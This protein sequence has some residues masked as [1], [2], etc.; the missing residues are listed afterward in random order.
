[1]TAAQPNL[2]AAARPLALVVDDSPFLAARLSCELSALGFEPRIAADAAQ[3]RVLAADAA[4]I[5]V[6]LELFQSCGFE[7]ARELAGQHACPL[8]LLT[9]S[10][11]KTD[12]QWGLRAGASAVLPR[13]LN[14]AALQTTLARLGCTGVTA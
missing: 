1:M 3:A 9:G 2:L 8:V 12:L 10:G 4:V 11:R 14:V 6:E 7:V 13:P 5:F